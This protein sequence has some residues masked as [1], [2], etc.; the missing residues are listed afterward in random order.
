MRRWGDLD[1]KKWVALRPYCNGRAMTFGKV[2]NSSSSVI[3]VS[4][5]KNVQRT[6]A[7]LLGFHRP[8]TGTSFPPAPDPDPAHDLLGRRDP[9]QRSGSGAREGKDLLGQ[10]QQRFAPRPRPIH[11][12]Q[13]AAVRFRNLPAQR[14]PDP[15][16][17]RFR[18]EERHE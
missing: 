9:F 7:S 4:A 1:S 11:Q 16:T 17:T 14:Q 13:R 8:D 10:P 12:A 15:G 18:G 5:R 2:V 3:C 6:K